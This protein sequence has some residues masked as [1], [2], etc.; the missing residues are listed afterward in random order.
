MREIMINYDGKHSKEFVNEIAIS[1]K[2]SFPTYKPDSILSSEKGFILFEAQTIWEKSDMIRV[3]DFWL[4]I[5]A[6]I[7]FNKFLKQIA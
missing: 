2:V 5:P 7:A 6:A 4:I 3:N 1:A